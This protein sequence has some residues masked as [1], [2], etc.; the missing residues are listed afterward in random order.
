MMH[1]RR[2]APEDS[3][4]F[5]ELRLAA[6]QDTP[7]AFGS[8]FEEERVLPISEI[9]RRLSKEFSHARFGAFVGQELVGLCGL[10][11]ETQ[12]N[13][14]HK[15]LV[16]GLYVKPAYRGQGIAK[17]LLLK[18]LDFA[19]SIHEIRQVNLIVNA[20]N[21]R[22]IRLYESLGFKVFGREPGALLVNGELHDEVHMFLRFVER[23]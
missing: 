21:E 20:A 4:A 13:L 7:S 14:S 5:Q 19:S 1:I 18:I 2:L 17:A 3:A 12:R 10:D 9:V 11:R 15:A 16:W 23:S 6:L 8:S 22:G